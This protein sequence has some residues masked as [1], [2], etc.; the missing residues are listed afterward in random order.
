MNQIKTYVI[1]LPKDQKRRENALRETGRFSN[2]DVEMVKAVYGKELTDQEKERLFDFKKYRQYYGRAV[3]SGEI[4]CT[5]SHRE[6]YKRL[7]DS[8]QQFALLLEDDVHFLVD[9]LDKDF[10]LAAA[11]M[12]NTEKP[13]VLLLHAEISYTGKEK[14]FCEGYSFYSVYNA[15]YTTA[16]FINRSAANLLLQKERPFWVADDWFRFRQ[17]GLNILCVYPS[18]IVQQWEQ[19]ASSILEE[20]RPYSKKRKLPH[21]WI[22]CRLA[23]EKIVYTL[24]E[25]LR[26]IKHI[27]G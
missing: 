18:A 5:L 14:V 10:W 17:W 4:G 25:G 19:L 3:L 24:L 11:E 9:P 26:I 22:E 7:L 16:Y 12:M 6:C 27:Q 2:L 20:K 23:Y 21:S 15:V 1:N 8:N 13:L